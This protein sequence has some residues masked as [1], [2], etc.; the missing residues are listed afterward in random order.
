MNGVVNIEKNSQPALS[1]QIVVI[2][3]HASEN[4]AHFN[5]ED[6]KMLVLSMAM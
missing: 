4:P 1:K 3:G 6:D 5:G 2:L